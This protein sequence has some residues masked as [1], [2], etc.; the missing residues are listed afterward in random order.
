MRTITYDNGREFSNH[1]RVAQALTCEDYFATP[2][3]SCER[4]TN[5]NSNG[6]LPQCFPKSM[7][8]SEVGPEQVQVAVD[9]LN[10]RPGNA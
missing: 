5:E 3:R 4:G 10:N 6:L 1:G 7:T 8:L 9:R 2:H